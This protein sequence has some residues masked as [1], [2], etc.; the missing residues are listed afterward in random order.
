MNG[1]MLTAPFLFVTT[2]VLIGLLLAAVA[3]LLLRRG[4]FRAPP[5]VTHAQAIV[6]RVHAVGK[7]V[8]LE[9]NAKEIATAT[10]G[11]SWLPPVLLSRARL[12]MIFRF[13]QQYALDLSRVT[14]DDISP[15]H[16]PSADARRRYRLRVPDLDIA[17][18]LTDV[19]P[20]DIQS[21]R[22]LGLV[23]VI[24]MN[25]ARQ[26]ELMRRAQE[27]AA[28]LFG[29]REQY[30]AAAR[31]AAER[32]LRALLALVDAEVEIAWPEP[33]PRPEG[34]GEPEP[35]ANTDEAPSAEPR[36]LVARAKPRARPRLRL[37]SA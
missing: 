25:A 14:A 5:R 16:A 19:T 6:D 8:A 10:Q 22:V 13:E 3:F 23:D 26:G 37:V 31:A 12:A 2:G 4:G 11:W 18:R 17:L 32:Q 35:Q 28:A 27:D 20:Y 34:A 29:D 7:L 36:P 33:R 9:V 30:R 1:M 24:P 15:L 21:G